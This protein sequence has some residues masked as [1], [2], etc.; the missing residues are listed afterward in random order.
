MR[1]KTKFAEFFLIGSVLKTTKKS[2]I[3]LQ[4]LGVKMKELKISNLVKQECL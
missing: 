4:I 2:I 1:I 3:S